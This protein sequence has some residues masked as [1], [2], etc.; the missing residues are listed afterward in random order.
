MKL[1]ERYQLLTVLMIALLLG[2]CSPQTQPP[3][4]TNTQAQPT[5]SIIPTEGSQE[6]EIHNADVISA[7]VSGEPGSYQF[8]VEIRSPDLGCEQYADWWE[9]IDESGELLYRRILLHSHVNEQPFT[10][11]GGPVPVEADTI[12]WIRAHMNEGGYGGDVLKGSPSSGFESA[13]IQPD[14]AAEFN[15]RLAQ[16]PP[17]PEDCAF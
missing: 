9:V 7:S 3:I 4:P 2:S 14:L 11:S 1:P 16:T 6:M 17:L 8:S 12:V 13:E 10:R 15:P 5:E